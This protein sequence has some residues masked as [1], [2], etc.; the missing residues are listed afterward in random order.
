MCGTGCA[1]VRQIRGENLFFFT[2]SFD[3]I[4][5]FFLFYS[6]PF[7]ETQGVQIDWGPLT[8]AKQM[9]SIHP[10]SVSKTDDPTRGDLAVFGWGLYGHVA[11][12]TGV[13]LSISVHIS[14]TKH[15]LHFF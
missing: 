15:A 13:H 7:L 6:L 5:S 14:Q 2:L 1:L 11:L 8:A 12:I 4:L 9:C 3:L 10:S